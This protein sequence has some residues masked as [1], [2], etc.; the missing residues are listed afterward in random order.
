MKMIET[1]ENEIEEMTIPSRCLPDVDQSS[2]QP[3]SKSAFERRDTGDDGS[4]HESDLW[5]L[6]APGSSSSTPRSVVTC[7]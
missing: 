2:N 5:Q 3:G 1:S 7:Q 4:C 6:P